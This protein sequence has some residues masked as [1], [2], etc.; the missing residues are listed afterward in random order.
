MSSAEK[1]DPQQEKDPQ[2]KKDPQQEPRGLLGMKLSEM[3]ISAPLAVGAI[4]GVFFAVT[5]CRSNQPRLA[6]E[7]VSGALRESPIDVDVINKDLDLIERIHGSVTEADIFR[8]Q[9]A[10]R[11]ID[12]TNQ[13]SVKD[14][15]LELSATLERFKDELAT[16]EDA[17]D[18]RHL[19]GV[20]RRLTSIETSL[21]KR[22]EVRLY[23]FE[24]SVAIENKSRL[25]TIVVREAMV[26]V[27]HD[28]QTYRDVRI[29]MQ[30]EQEQP[31]TRH[32]Q[33]RGLE[34]VAYSSA[35]IEDGSELREF[36]DFDRYSNARCLF[37]LRDIGGRTWAQEDRCVIDRNYVEDELQANLRDEFARVLRAQGGSR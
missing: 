34:R 32:I 8:L 3:I 9:S 14:F 31:H 36:L 13:D 5:E 4:V 24:V 6:I 15:Q 26:R 29:Y 7:F 2:Q 1:K 35:L 11:A 18:R 25:E 21:A 37:I 10:L 19:S 28:S 23:T 17:A 20:V 16:A 27:W 22:T 12:A 33:G 30:Q